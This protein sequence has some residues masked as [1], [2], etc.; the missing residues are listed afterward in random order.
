MTTT[1]TVG[2]EDLRRTGWQERP[3]APL[4]PGAVRLHID[5]FAL[6][7]NNISYGAFGEGMSYW[8][9]FPTGDATTGCIPVWGFATVSESRCDGVAVGERFYGYY[10]MA[11]EVVL[12]PVAIDA[13]ASSTARRTVASCTASTTSTFVA[14]ATRSIAR[15][16]GRARPVPAA[17]QHVVPDRR[18]PGRQRLLRRRRGAG[19]ERLEQDRLRPRLLLAARRASAAACRA[20]A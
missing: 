10:P 20:S 13:S 3:E 1:F 2:K 16:R 4:D 12:Q 9:F 15:R 19:V 17:L 5:R 18:L 14:R 11:D 8:S 7:S 6:T